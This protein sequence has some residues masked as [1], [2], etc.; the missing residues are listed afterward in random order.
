MAFMTEALDQSAILLP[1]HVDDGLLARI[2]DPC[3]VQASQLLPDP[4]CALDDEMSVDVIADHIGPVRLTFKKRRYCRPNG[5]ISYVSWLS[6]HAE[7]AASAE[8]SNLSETKGRKF[9]LE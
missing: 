1:T 9:R 7:S 4:A 8:S 2:S 5:K 3:V 6:R